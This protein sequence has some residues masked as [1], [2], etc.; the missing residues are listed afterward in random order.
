[1]QFR[2]HSTL[3]VYFRR[4]SGVI[5]IAP[6]GFSKVNMD[7]LFQVVVIDTSQEGVGYDRKME[8]KD[9]GM[10]GNW[11]CS[12]HN[13]LCNMRSKNLEYILH[14]VSILNLVE[15][16]KRNTYTPDNVWQRLAFSFRSSAHP[17]PLLLTE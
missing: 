8:Q 7:A 13:A 16:A 3:I 12:R 15:R 6:G 5:I 11:P 2:Q 17:S 4:P 9:I 14:S 1:M 10:L